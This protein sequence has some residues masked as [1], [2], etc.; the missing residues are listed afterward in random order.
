MVGLQA[1]AGSAPKH[2]GVSG[3]R[4]F[5]RSCPS[6]HPDDPAL[7]PFS[8]TWP[9]EAKAGLR[10]PGPLGAVTLRACAAA[11]RIYG[12]RKLRHVWA[13]SRPLPAGPPRRAPRNS[14]APPF[15]PRSRASNT[16]PA[17]MC[18][19][20]APPRTRPSH[21]PTS[22]RHRELEEAGG[23][24][25]KSYLALLAPPSNARRRPP[26]GGC[27]PHGGPPHRPAAL[28]PSAQEF[29]VASRPDPVQPLKKELGPVEY[30]QVARCSRA[31]RSVEPR[32]PSRLPVVVAPSSRCRHM[33]DSPLT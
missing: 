31:E 22:E 11:E 7:G 2:D 28:A 25:A 18:R 26:P 15:I 14:L 3:P 8:L 24:P 16:M 10:W 32:D 21:A 19:G 13:R 27:A 9:A 6:I 12:A 23:V 4:K 17:R 30:L 1:V 20:G 33:L 29:H 5:A